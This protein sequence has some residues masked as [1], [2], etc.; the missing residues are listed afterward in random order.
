MSYDP[1]EIKEILKI[2]MEDY[3]KYS[4]TNK[5]KIYQLRKKNNQT[6]IKKNNI[7]VITEYHNIEPN[8]LI[9]MIDL[10]KLQHKKEN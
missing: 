5:D 10:Y 8:E 2:S 9:K 7:F 6:E 1:K 4:N 3:Y